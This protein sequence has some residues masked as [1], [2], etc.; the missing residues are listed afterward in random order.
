MGFLVQGGRPSWGNTPHLILGTFRGKNKDPCRGQ[1]RTMGIP[2]EEA[3]A[4]VTFLRSYQLERRTYS[5][6]HTT[7]NPGRTRWYLGLLWVGCWTAGGDGPSGFPLLIYSTRYA[8]GLYTA[9]CMRNITYFA[10]LGLASEL[11]R[12]HEKGSGHPDRDRGC[13]IGLL[14][15][16]TPLAQPRRKMKVPGLAVTRSDEFHNGARYTLFP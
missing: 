2:N 6:H 3:T 8:R 1:M 15:V 5:G 4:L 16:T 10:R 13:L 12:L 11:S 14:P 9:F 7:P